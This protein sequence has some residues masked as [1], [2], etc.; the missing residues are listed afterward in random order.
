MGAD[1]ERPLTPDDLFHLESIDPMSPVAITADGQSFAYV[2]RRAKIT[3]NTF[4]RLFLAGRDHADVWL[5]FASGDPPRNLTN[6]SDDNSGFWAPKWSPDGQR[7]AMLSTRGGNVRV[8]VWSKASG[9]LEMLSS[10]GTNATTTDDLLWLSPHELAFSVLPED[11][12]NWA[13]EIDRQ[14]QDVARV[15]LDKVWEGQRPTASLLESGVPS[16]MQNRP[17]EQLLVVNVES[18]KEQVIATGISFFALSISP[19]QRFLAFLDQDGVWHPDSSLGVVK[20]LLPKI[21]RLEVTDIQNGFRTEVMEGVQETG[22]PRGPIWSPDSTELAVVNWAELE[23]RTRA[24]IG[25]EVIRCSVHDARCRPAITAQFV[26]SGTALWHDKHSLIVLAYERGS[27]HHNRPRA[28]WWAVD[29]DGKAHEFLS[30]TQDAPNP[31]LSQA[32]GLSLIGIIRG[33]LWRIDNNGR[34]TQNLTQGFGANVS[35]IEWP[36]SKDNTVGSELIFSARPRTGLYRLT[37]ETGKITPFYKPLP[38]AS[39]IGYDAKGGV[40]LFTMHNRKGTYLWLKKPNQNDCPTVLQTNEFLRDI[41]EGDLEKLE[42]RGSDGQ[43]LKAWMILPL[44]YEPGRRYPTIAWVYAGQVYG[45]EPPEDLVRIN[46]PSPLNLQL[47]AAHGYL[48]LLPSMPRKPFGEVSDPYFELAKGVL[49][50]LDKLVALGIADPNRIGV[51][52]HSYGGFSTYGLITQ[53][54][55][56][57]AAIALAGISDFSSWYGTFDARMRY[58]PFVHEDTFRMQQIE[59][60]TMGNPPWRDVTRYSRNAPISYADRVKTPLLI[61]QG[62]LDYVPIQQGEEFFTAL[63]RLNK[64]AQF[65]R[66]W[67]EDHTLDSPANIRDM[68]QRIYYWLDEFVG[69]TMNR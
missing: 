60:G 64:R 46:D 7:L 24:N 56:F 43:H 27:Q 42:Y 38:D 22:V 6:G 16:S 54:H 45:D 50:A 11:K 25:R 3:A 4:G 62:D 44:G 39:L 41:F 14:T 36:Q 19:D 32:G 35:S 57:Q 65:V 61:I 67:G 66:Y 5:A 51:M 2:I 18:G 12:K 33:S 10:H 55:R 23:P 48:V 29:D 21:W 31:L 13:L 63:Y 9:R 47:L 69:N 20:F 53:T 59:G 49:P 34:P 68:W 28:K 40:G 15:E 30:P 58:D 1:Q 26:S 37:L 17:L 52:G 8:W